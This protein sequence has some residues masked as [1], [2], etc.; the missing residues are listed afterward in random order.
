MRDASEPQD[1][2][3]EQPL[4]PEADE[5]GRGDQGRASPKKSLTLSIH[6]PR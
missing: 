3:P 5:Q 2:Q 6:S 1:A 4:K